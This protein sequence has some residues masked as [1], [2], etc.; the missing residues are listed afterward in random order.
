MPLHTLGRMA[1]P[2]IGGPGG[3]HLALRPLIILLSDFTIFRLLMPLKA[4]P[5]GDVAFGAARRLPAPTFVK[6]V[7]RNTWYPNSYGNSSVE[8]AQSLMRE[9]GPLFPLLHDINCDFS[10]NHINESCPRFVKTRF[11]KGMAWH[12]MTCARGSLIL[13]LHRPLYLRK[14]CGTSVQVSGTVSSS[15]LL[16]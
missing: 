6:S 3:L 5:A 15:L 16:D 13:T 10:L 4:K 12:G 8:G 1:M 14:Q 11:G 7:I 2:D 9:P